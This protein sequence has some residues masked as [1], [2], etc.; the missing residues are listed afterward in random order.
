MCCVPRCAVIL[1]VLTGLTGCGPSGPLKGPVSGTVS[2]DGKPLDEG[3]IYFK[4][5][6]EGL[7]EQID[8]KE[9]KFEGMAVVGDRQV[10]IYRY[11]EKKPAKVRGKGPP[12]GFPA[13]KMNNIPARYSTESTLTAAVTESGPNEFK[14][15]LASK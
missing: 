10:E 3:T 11:V 12:S 9:G 6:R 15:E 2:L 7:I 5:A 8:I 13:L 14:F 1:V 4:T